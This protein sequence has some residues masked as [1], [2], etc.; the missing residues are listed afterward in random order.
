MRGRRFVAI[1][2]DRRRFPETI[3]EA[4]GRFGLLIHGY[5]LMPNH[6]QLLLETPRANLSA[7]AGW[8][9]TTYRVR[10]N[11]RHRRSGHLF[12]FVRWD[13]RSAGPP[14]NPDILHAAIG[15][16]ALRWSHPT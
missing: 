16:P 9:Q 10:F 5:C 11:R 6:D 13:Q 4:L 15:G 3:D 2:A 8:L 7:S 14:L 1:A 12:Q